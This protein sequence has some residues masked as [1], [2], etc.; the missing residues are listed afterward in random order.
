MDVVININKPE[1][2]TSQG[3]V[4][5]V[6]RMLC[7]KKAGHTGTL[8]PFATGVLPVCTGKATKLFSRLINSDKEY[9]AAIKIGESTDT[10]DSSG[11]II[12]AVNTSHITE[13]MVMDALQRFK[14]SISQIPPMYSAL[15]LN[16]T[17][18]YKLARRGIIVERKA[19]II[20]IHH[21]EILGIALPFITLHIHCSAGTYIRTLAYDIGSV[22]GV[23]GHL[24][25]L[26]RIRAGQFRIEDSIR[27][28]ELASYTKEGR[29]PKGMYSLEQVLLTMSN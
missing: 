9:I 16:G 26:S 25:S 22:L 10:E 29:T 14:G 7:I 24:V 18:L 27:L 12:Q 23:G 21:I 3:V 5:R 2:I 8:D 20:T 11:T 1:G 6:K 17:P 4:N 15:K 28:D 13:G 19:R